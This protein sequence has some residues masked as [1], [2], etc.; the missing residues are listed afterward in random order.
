MNLG[1]DDMVLKGEWVVLFFYGKNEK[2]RCVHAC[3]G[4]VICSL[5]DCFFL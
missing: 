3:N 4:D 5:S 1:M 2:N